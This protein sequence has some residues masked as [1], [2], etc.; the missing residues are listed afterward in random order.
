MRRT[1]AYSLHEVA[2]IVGPQI[3]ERALLSVFDGFLSDLEEVKIGVVSH[4][5]DFLAQ[6][7]P[8]Q[9]ARYGRVIR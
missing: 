3:T 1:L 9:R 8:E 2:K 4:F 7:S 6:L 5:A